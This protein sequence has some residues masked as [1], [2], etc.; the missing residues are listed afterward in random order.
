MPFK[1]AISLRSLIFQ[2]SLVYPSLGVEAFDGYGLPTVVLPYDM[3]QVVL[4]TQA[5]LEWVAKHSFKGKSNLDKGIKECQN[6]AR[7]SAEEVLRSVLEPLSR[8][9]GSE[10]GLR[11]P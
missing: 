4:R 7:H 9:K 10:G 5:K 8:A 6:E 2:K 11:I 1:P 3:M